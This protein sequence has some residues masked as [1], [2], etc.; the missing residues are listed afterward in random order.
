MTAK[1]PPTAS[2]TKTA[3]DGKLV[4][5]AAARNVAPLTTL[6]QGVAPSTGKALELASGTGQHVVAFAAAL[7]GLMWQPTEIAAD[8]RASIDA[9]REEAQLPNLATA[10]DLNA[11][12]SGW[13][14][15]VPPQDLILCINLLHLVSEPD[16]HTLVEEAA[17]A[18]APNGL[19]L[20]YGPFKR[21]GHLT[22][23]GDAR[24][25][26]QLRDADPAIGYKDAGDIRHWLGETGLMTQPPHPMPANNLAL[27]A[28]KAVA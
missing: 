11:C 27:M 21:D 4:A 8:R 2:V 14:D 22:S 6:L 26:A 17:R 16:A 7:P 24:F 19:L 20:I 10:R 25:D 3:A 12:A 1:L 18:L 23:E 9:Y 15:C 28:R 13:A 5:P